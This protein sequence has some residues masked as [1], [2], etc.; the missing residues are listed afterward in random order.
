MNGGTYYFK[1]NIFKYITNKNLSLENELLPKL[2]KQKKINGKI[3]KN[4]FIDIGSKQ[5]LKM[6]KKKLKKH[7]EKPAVFLDRDGVIN[8]DYG[9]VHKIKNFKF[10]P[11]V[12]LGLKYLLKKNYYL[13]IIT[14]QAGIG[15]KKFK[16]IQFIR[17]HSEINEKL[18]NLISFLMI[19]NTHLF[20]LRPKLKNIK[21]IHR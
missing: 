7:F 9:Y 3:F 11:G 18:K 2:I 6:A 17:L 16:E 13:F 8:Y 21:K 1:K 15:K 10:R 20:I 12:L 19:F 5:Y 4:F 14:N